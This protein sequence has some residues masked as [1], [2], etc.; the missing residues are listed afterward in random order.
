MN[1][2][3]EI[4]LQLTLKAIDAGLI[5]HK[6]PFSKEGKADDPSAGVTKFNEYVAKQISDFYNNILKSISS[7]DHSN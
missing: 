6:I 3:Q 2:N 7:N 1:S 5:E 4:A